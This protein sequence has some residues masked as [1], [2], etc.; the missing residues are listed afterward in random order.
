MII[1]RVK[2]LKLLDKIYNSQEAEFLVVYGRRRVGKTYLI[3]EYFTSQKCKLL[4]ATGLQHGDGVKDGVR[5][6]TGS[7]LYNCIFR[8]NTIKRLLQ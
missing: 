1:G 8:F 4:H 2:E 7:G 6:E 5:L 3:R